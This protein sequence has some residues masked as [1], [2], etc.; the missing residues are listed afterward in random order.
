LDATPVVL[1]GEPIVGMEGARGG[2]GCWRR[3][4]LEEIGEGT[5]A[6]FEGFLE[7]S[8]RGDSGGVD[9]EI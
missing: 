4:L 7:G 6:A 2:V 3:L 8:R 5:E 1:R 9:E